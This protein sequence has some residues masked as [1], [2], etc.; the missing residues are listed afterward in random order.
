MSFPIKILVGFL[1]LIVA[2]G[3]FILFCF[4][5]GKRIVK[6]HGGGMAF[7]NS[8]DVYIKLKSN[9]GGASLICHNGSVNKTLCTGN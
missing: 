6:V 1:L 5:I 3:Y 4:W 7:N 2:L 9:K 8:L